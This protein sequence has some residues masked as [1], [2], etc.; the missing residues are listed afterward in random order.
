MT[1]MAERSAR[2]VLAQLLKDRL[3]V[4][5]NPKGAVSFNFSLDALNVLL[6]NLYPEAATTNNEP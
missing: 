6:P 1:G 3:L 5:D 2:R 4:S